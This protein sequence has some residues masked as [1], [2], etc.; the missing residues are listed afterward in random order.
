MKKLLLLSAMFLSM[1]NVCAQREVTKFLGIPV[2]GYKPEMI[3]KLKAKGFI[4]DQKN[5][6]LT[7]EFNGVDVV[8]KI[9]T[10]NNKVYRIMLSDAHQRSETDIR[11]RF[12]NLIDQFSRNKRY[13]C[14]NPSKFLIP[15]N[16]DISYEM[17]VKSKRYEAIFFQ[18]GTKTENVDS[19]IEVE[20]MMK[21]SVWFMIGELYSKYYIIMFY[22]NEWNHADGEDL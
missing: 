16:E 21:R 13:L 1:L 20:N 15:D 5:D 18:M 8:L 3:Q 6:C 14:A 7:G 19:E 11:I 4:Y 9:V 17:G 2:D 22:D 10:N 12:N